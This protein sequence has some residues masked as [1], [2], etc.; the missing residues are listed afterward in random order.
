MKKMI[1]LCALMLT[2]AA[3]FGQESRQDVSI[4]GFGLIG[5]TVHGN[6]VTEQPT[7]TAGVLVSYRYLLTPRSGL[8]LNY[9]FAQYTDKFQSGGQAVN[10]Y[11]PIHV[12]QQELSA[13]YVYGRTYGNYTPFVEAGVGGVV[14][15]PILEGSFSLD[16]K[17]NTT[18]GGLVGGGLAYEISPSFDVRVQYR[19]LI[20]K[21]PDFHLP[22]N[23][24]STGR[25]EVINMPA[26]GI[27]YHF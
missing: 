21:A 8:E 19:G 15:T 23:R 12:R 11:N 14:F 5:P 22:G 2:G 24:F 4:S 16:A 6:A 18:I 13:A 1:V 9:S 7:R 17:Q 26:I 10:T 25:Y 20:V 27:A 3:A